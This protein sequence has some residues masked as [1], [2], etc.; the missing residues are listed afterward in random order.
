MLTTDDLQVFTD[1][2][3]RTMFE[4]AVTLDRPQA[5]EFW[6]LST[7]EYRFQHTLHVRRFV[8]RLQA[9]EGGDL[10]LLQTSAIFHDISHFSTTYDQHGRVSAEMARDYLTSHRSSTGEPFPA[11]FIDRVFLTIDDH[12]SD[13]PSSYYLDEVPLESML[14]IEADLLDKLGPNGAFAHLLLSGANHRL[15]QAALATIERDVIGRGERA[16]GN[17]GKRFH[18]T[19]VARRMIEERLAWTK[20]FLAEVR[21]DVACLF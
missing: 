15:W 11:D 1:H 2:V 9:E 18:L 20:H 14:L 4:C 7:P 12:A 13:K 19:P 21:E 16:L 6:P 5:A 10:E 8:E 3:R 17:D